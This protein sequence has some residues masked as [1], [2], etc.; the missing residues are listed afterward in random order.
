MD[1]KYIVKYTS[2]FKKDYKLIQKRGYDVNK[3]F[4]VISLIAEGTHEAD[5]K[6]N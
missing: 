6:K 4:S 5:L 3:L 1:N 2:R